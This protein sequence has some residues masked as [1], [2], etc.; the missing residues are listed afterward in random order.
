MSDFANWGHKWIMSLKAD[1]EPNGAAS[2]ENRTQ[3]M[4][5]YFMW[6][7]TECFHYA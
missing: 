3:S 1:T 5:S 2:Y 7:S 6:T 4:L